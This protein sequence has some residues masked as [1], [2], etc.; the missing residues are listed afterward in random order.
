MPGLQVTAGPKT[1]LVL[2]GAT[3]LPSHKLDN[4]IAGKVWVD[5]LSLRGAPPQELSMRWQAPWY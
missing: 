5:D 3:R 4:L 2:G 1:N